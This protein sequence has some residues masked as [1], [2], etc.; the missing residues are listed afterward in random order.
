MCFLLHKWTKWEQYEVRF[1]EYSIDSEE[2]SKEWNF[3]LRQRR[4]C[5][6]CGKMQDILLR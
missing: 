3:Q 5:K 6:E 4:T 2:E 1:R